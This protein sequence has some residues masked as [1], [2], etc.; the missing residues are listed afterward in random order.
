MI[1]KFDQSIN[2]IEADKKVRPFGLQVTKED[3]LNGIKKRFTMPDR[4]KNE[5]SNEDTPEKE[6]GG[7]F[8]RIK[9]A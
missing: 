8:Q 2:N 3:I 1:Q 7:N 4:V 9:L 6:Q 5:I